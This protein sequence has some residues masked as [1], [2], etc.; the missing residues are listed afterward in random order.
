MLRSLSSSSTA[1][2]D[3]MHPRATASDSSDS[4]DIDYT[5]VKCTPQRIQPSTPILTPTTNIACIMTL[6]LGNVHLCG[7]NWIQV[8][9]FQTLDLESGPLRTRAH[10]THHIVL[11]PQD[12]HHIS[13]VS[14]HS[15]APS[16]IVDI[17]ALSCLSS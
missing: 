1:I 8:P 17:L 4:D 11:T 6:Y 14:W 13:V 9:G 12:T 10:S 15:F 7:T 3:K 5:P 2:H 16:C